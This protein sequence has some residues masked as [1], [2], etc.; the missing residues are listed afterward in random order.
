MAR[1]T[2]TGTDADQTQRT[3]RRGGVVKDM[4]LEELRGEGISC[5]PARQRRRFEPPGQ[6]VG[7]TDGRHAGQ[8]TSAQRRGLAWIRS[9][10][11]TGRER[12]RERDWEL[13]AQPGLSR[14]SPGRFIQLAGCWTSFWHSTGQ[15]TGQYR[16]LA[17]QVSA[18]L[19]V[20]LH[21]CS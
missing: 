12:N 2:V 21:Y 15:Y 5:R 1:A 10:G 13:G 7:D 14:S 17:R 19:A 20:N 11:E 3:A 8:R 18:G 9:L 6:L 4:A 16:G